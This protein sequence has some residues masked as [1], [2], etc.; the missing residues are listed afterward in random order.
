[1]IIRKACEKV[2]PAEFANKYFPQILRISPS[3]SQIT[4]TYSQNPSDLF[5]K[6][7]RLSRKVCE[8]TR[9]KKLKKL[10]LGALRGFFPSGAAAH[11]AGMRTR[12]HQQPWRAPAMKKKPTDLAE[13]FPLFPNL[14]LATRPAQTKLKFRKRKLKLRFRHASTASKA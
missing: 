1:M 14:P 4:S 7:C 8:R 11:P 2:L 6:S 5:A 10:N 9:F 12:S 13:P 3:Y